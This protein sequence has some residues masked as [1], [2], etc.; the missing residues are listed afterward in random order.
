MS[1]AGL[2]YD[3]DFVILWV[4][5]N[6]TEW[7]KKRGGF[8]AEKDA[9][10]SAKR[11]RDWDNLKYWFRGVSKFTPWVRRIH[12]VSDGQLPGWLNVSDGRINTVN[13]SD[14]IPK[15]YLPVFN[16]NA[17][18]IGIHNIP[19][20]SDKFVLFNDDFF[21]IKEISP[22]YFFINGMP[23]DMAGLT[24][25]SERITQTGKIW[26]NNYNVLNRYFNKNKVIASN[27]GA[28]LDPFY[29]KTFLRTV[30]NITRKE[31]DVIVIPHLSTPYLKSDFE[32]VWRV[33]PKELSQTQSSRFRSDGDLSHFLFRFWRLCEGKFVPKR[34]KGR[35]FS[36]ENME[37]IKRIENAI[38][39]RRYPEICINDCWDGEGF[40]EAKKR[41]AD[42]F[43]TILPEK[44]EFE[45]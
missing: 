43:E 23:V 26:C 14:F 39:T 38:T 28:W 12:F 1:R 41:V 16:S 30:V 34:P 27:L 45:K 5:G 18:E 44:C 9:D 3:I 29:G 15:E 35:Y 22:E 37:S 40:E 4:D 32:K 42:A 8:R 20:L 33:I 24:A 25:S 2:K 13:H 11:Y 31:F 17:I 36:A 10:L 21:I 19:G 7:Q 6:D